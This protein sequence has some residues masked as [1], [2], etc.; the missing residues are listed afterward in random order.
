[1]VGIHNKPLA[2][3]AEADI[4]SIYSSLAHHLTASAGG[5][6]ESRCPT[7]LH[8]RASEHAGK[9]HKVRRCWSFGWARGIR[10]KTY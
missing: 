7:Y 3:R 9:N 8:S 5:G 10:E 1:M 6:S 4:A 2:G